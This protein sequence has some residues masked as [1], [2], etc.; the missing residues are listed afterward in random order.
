MTTETLV[1]H[2]FQVGDLVEGLNPDGNPA[3]GRITAVGLKWLRIDGPGKAVALDS[4][5]KSQ[6]CVGDHVII[7]RPGR[8]QKS[9]EGR[10]THI[11]DTKAWPVV[12]VALDRGRTW[13]I[14]ADRLDLVEPVQSTAQ[15][16]RRSA[17]NVEPASDIQPHTPAEAIAPIEVEIVPSDPTER[18]AQIEA[19]VVEGERL[20][21]EGQRLILS[22]IAQVVDEPD[23]LTANGYGDVHDWLERKFDW[24]RSNRFKAIKAAKA[25]ASVDGKVA[26]LPDSIHAFNALGSV[27]ERDRAEVLEQAGGQSATA[28][29]IKAVVHPR[30]AVGDRVICREHPNAADD[31]IVQKVT[32]KR[33]T[34]SSESQEE[35]A[36]KL[37]PETLEPYTEQEAFPS[38]SP[39]DEVIDLNPINPSERARILTV[40]STYKNG[41]VLL[42]SEDDA[43]YSIHRSGL[44]LS[45]HIED[46]PVYKPDSSPEAIREGIEAG[47]ITPTADAPMSAEGK[48]ILIDDHIAHAA[49]ATQLIGRVTEYAEGGRIAYTR[50]GKTLYADAAV[51]VHQRSVAGPDKPD[52]PQSS[53]P[54]TELERGDLVE[55]G[56]R[57]RVVGRVSERG[58]VQLLGRNPETL[59]DWSDAFEDAPA[60]VDADADPLGLTL[61]TCCQ[62][63]LG[64]MVKAF[65]H[66][67]V[68]QTLEV[69]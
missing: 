40:K 29:S 68:Q 1:K 60:K 55:V 19:D 65:G 36:K 39:G 32:Q 49:E 43:A 54:A 5:F 48:P 21:K 7:A 26:E 58:A 15:D 41:M 14:E 53:Q 6:L 61:E 24:Q 45:R 16:E 31:W 35:V 8:L 62:S 9:L 17:S 47:Y 63:M 46:L 23:I 2:E 13:P 38:F 56:P 33:I 30:F 22:A 4:A 11:T 50:M 37:L 64:Q 42:F 12:S 51:V 34:C 3:R 67:L 66:D 10:E 44:K 28:D 20:A 57:Y 59:N 18:L 25:F 27:P 52:T 69:L